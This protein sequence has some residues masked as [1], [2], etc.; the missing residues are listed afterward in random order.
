MKL[1]LFFFSLGFST[2]FQAQNGDELKNFINKNEIAIRS[3]QKNMLSQNDLTYSNQFKE[4]LKNQIV[5][6]KQYNSHKDISC[7]YAFLVRNESLS[8]IKNNNSQSL[9]F[10]NIIE[11][12]NNMVKSK[13]NN[14]I[15]LS[16]D[17]L[18]LIQYLDVLNPSNL[19]QFTLT[20]Q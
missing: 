13:P 20:V 9:E 16:V 19:N 11:S 8:Y 4:L 15:K 1:I 17:E 5:S 12:E 14:N 6:V 18:K 7:H 2:I 10:Y 3:I